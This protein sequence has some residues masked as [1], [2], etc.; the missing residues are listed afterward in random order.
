MNT[1]LIPFNLEKAKAGA[2][3]V[4]HDGDP[5]EIVTLNGRGAYPV[6]GYVG[7][8]L[9]ANTWTKD[10]Q[11]IN[12]MNEPPALFLSV[13]AFPNPP[14]GE[15][16]HNPGNLTPEQVG[17]GYRLLLK[18][19]VKVRGEGVKFI[20]CF[21]ENAWSDNWEG[22]L[23]KRTYRLPTS[24]PFHWE[25]PKAPIYIP[26]T[27]ETIQ[28]HLGRV[29]KSKDGTTYALIICCSKTGVGVWSGLRHYDCLFENYTFLDGTPCGTKK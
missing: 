2:K 15:E 24:I 9:I 22:S 20:E 28:P 10:G 4:H 11:A 14:E 25:A 1:K 21:G 19:E 26:F 5:V 16:W 7:D 18:G 29:V 23:S 17:E 12:S 6:I 13:P 27:Y 8:S 3:V